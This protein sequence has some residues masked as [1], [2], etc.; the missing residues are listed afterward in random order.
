M[1]QQ[2]NPACGHIVLLQQRSI[3]F[4]SSAAEGVANVLKLDLRLAYELTDFSVQG[5]HTHHLNVA[6]SWPATYL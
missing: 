6:E 1:L 2:I 5:D 3:V 4:G